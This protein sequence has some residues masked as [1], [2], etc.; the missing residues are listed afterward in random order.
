MRRSARIRATRAAC[1]AGLLGLALSIE[2]RSEKRSLVLTALVS[3]REVS[4]ACVRPDGSAVAFTVTAADPKANRITDRIWM[5]PVDGAPARPFTTGPGCDWHP[6]FSTD[7]RAL[8]FLSDRSGTPQLYWMPVD[9]GEARLVTSDLLFVRDFDWSPDGS[10]FV[11]VADSCAPAAKPQTLPPA[12]PSFD[13]RHL[14]RGLPPRPGFEDR[15]RGHLYLAPRRGGAPTA[16]TSGDNDDF[17][18]VFT[19][20]GKAVV[21]VSNRSAG[22]LASGGTDLFVVPA[23]GGE[24]RALGAT[25]GFDHSPTVSPDAQWVAF[26]S[27]SIDVPDGSR[28]S[29]LIVP[30]QGGTAQNLTESSGLQLARLPG[31]VRPR[32]SPDGTTLYF[33]VAEAGD[34]TIWSI[35]RGSAAPRRIVLGPGENVDFTLTADGSHLAFIR[36]DV[37]APGELWLLSLSSPDLRCLTQ[38]NLATLSAVRFA[39]FE[40]MR[41]RPPATPVVEPVAEDSS[42]PADAAPAESAPARE[43]QAVFVKPLDVGSGSRQ[44]LVLYLPGGPGA[45]HGRHFVP[46]WQLLAASGYAVLA[47]GAGAEAPSTGAEDK[48]GSEALG[49]VAL[50]DEAIS[51]GGID[52]DRLGIVAWSE[53]AALAAR[54]LATTDRFR[55]VVFGIGLATETSTAAASDVAASDEASTTW[56]KGDTVKVPTLVLNAGGEDSVHALRMAALAASLRRRGTATETVCF[57]E[58]SILAERPSAREAFYRRLVSWLETRLEREPATP[59]PTPAPSTSPPQGH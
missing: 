22:F 52:P 35:V 5:S 8:A 43:I 59:T 6:R 27:G 47:V 40:A 13:H 31:A 3:L 19:P 16:L 55:C 12:L 42:A 32:F 49:I 38:M 2:A 1:A 34:T 29:L 57:E 33:A 44:P 46:A 25:P 36:S 50:L 18:P 23:T 58:P 56:P 30:V 4:D 14:R 39:A 15:R 26:L 28:D 51:R 11:L 48:L 24:P 7:G 54:L 10:Q 37:D 45:R 21:F 53:S 9:G 17:D 41:V 20:D